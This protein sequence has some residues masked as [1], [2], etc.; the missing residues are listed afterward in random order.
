M[1]RLR[2]SLLFPHSLESNLEFARAYENGE[3]DNLD[4]K[5]WNPDDVKNNKMPKV[6]KKILLAKAETYIYMPARIQAGLERNALFAIKGRTGKRSKERQ[7]PEDWTT[8]ALGPYKPENKLQDV[9]LQHF[10][11][12]LEA[13]IPSFVRKHINDVYI[14][15][16]DHPAYMATSPSTRGE[17]SIVFNIGRDM[18]FKEFFFDETREKVPA[19]LCND[20]IGKINPTI[21]SELFCDN[22]HMVWLSSQTIFWGHAFIGLHRLSKAEV[23]D[24]IK[25]G[26]PFTFKTL[27]EQFNGQ[28]WLG[29]A[30]PKHNLLEEVK[31]GLSQ[32]WM[33]KFSG[34][35]KKLSL[36]TSIWENLIKLTRTDPSTV[37]CF[38]FK[39]L[40]IAQP[41]F[42]TEDPTEAITFTLGRRLCTDLDDWGQEYHERTLIIP[43]PELRTRSIFR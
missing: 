39:T 12:V 22:K 28:A 43:A 42:V 1:S 34:R 11:N 9:R 33:E 20:V 8:I 32:K 5:S 29:R 31:K 24:A 38:G 19:N 13:V 25:E 3:I 40:Q 27:K 16:K 41:P 7:R 37:F 21:Q 23:L 35:N 10:P 2:I 36:D 30:V 15:H 18:S 14:V 6:P 4:L 26:Q 17:R